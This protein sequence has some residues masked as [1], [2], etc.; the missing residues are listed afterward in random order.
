MVLGIAFYFAYGRRN[1]RVGTRSES[2]EQE[3]LA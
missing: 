1:S 2:Q 3:A